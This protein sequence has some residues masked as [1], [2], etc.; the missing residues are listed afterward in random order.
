MLFVS[1]I[2]VWTEKVQADLLT[3]LLKKNLGHLGDI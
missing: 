2:R 1:E 3:I